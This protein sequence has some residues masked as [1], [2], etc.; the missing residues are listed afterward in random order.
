MNDTLHISFFI[1]SLA[2]GGAERV[3]VQVAGGLADRGHE[4]D[5]VVAN[6]E[7]VIADQL[8]DNVNRY[9]IRA[10][11]A[12]Y[13]CVPYVRYLLRR[14]PDALLS[15]LHHGNFLSIVSHY[16]TRW[17]GT[18]CT[19][20]PNDFLREEFGS[21]F[22]QKLT[23]VLGRL[24]Y[25]RADRVICVSGGVEES[26]KQI[27]MSRTRLRTIPNPVNASGIRD[28]AGA[29]TPDHPFFQTDGPVLLSVGRLE[30]QKDFSTLIRAFKKIRR[31]DV[32]LLILGDGSRRA[33]LERL[34]KQNGLEDRVALPGEVDN[35]YPYFEQADLFVL[36]SLW[37]GMPNVLLEA[38]TLGKTAVATDCPSGPAEVLEGG[39]FG[40]L[41]P[42]GDEQELA[43]TIEHALAHPL[44][45]E[46]VRRRAKDYSLERVVDAYESCLRTSI[47]QTQ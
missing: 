12:L 41:T 11:R 19:R 23:P 35:P 2:R 8:A 9:F 18:L 43:R 36:S 31:N 21:K 40:Y 30:K 24:L 3:F 29:Y 26:M 5:F 46:H 4:V 16:L 17:S 42:P 1:P 28:R 14:R 7:L 44:P 32:R 6:D 34:V 39:E 10:S 37:E 25:P 47:S 38:I 15:T 45:K 22:K 13:A 33:S 27:G 20:V